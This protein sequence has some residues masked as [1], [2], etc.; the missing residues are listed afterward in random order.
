M[1]S[2]KVTLGASNVADAH[3]LMAESKAPKNSTC[4]TNG[5]CSTTK[6]GN[7]FWGSSLMRVAAFSGMMI[8][9]AAR[10]LMIVFLGVEMMSIAVYVLAGLNRGSVRSAEGALKYFLLGAFSTGFLLYG[11]A[12][13]YGATGSTDIVVI[14]QR[15]VQ[16]SLTG[17]SM[18][19]IGVGLL[20]VGFVRSAVSTPAVPPVGR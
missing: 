19:L 8:M 18:L 5:I 9:A 20:L 17:H 1:F 11:I 4:M 2:V 7:T 6:V 15:I 3:D 14:G 12:L 16:Y 10:D 13:V